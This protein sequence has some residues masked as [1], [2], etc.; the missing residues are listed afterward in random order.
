MESTRRLEG[1]EFIGGEA[2]RKPEFYLVPQEEP[3]SPQEHGPVPAL[4]RVTWKLR[5][6]TGV[7]RPMKRTSSGHRTHEGI[8]HRCG[9]RGPVARVRRSIRTHLNMGR[10]YGR[11]CSDC[12]DHLGTVKASSRSMAT[13]KQG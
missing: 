9:W 11:L 13:T 2:A 7:T 3:E 8:C 6:D 5:G 12:I 4:Q 10:K 1:Q